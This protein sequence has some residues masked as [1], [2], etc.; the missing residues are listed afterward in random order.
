MQK[1]MKY[2]SAVALAAV[3]CLVSLGAEARSSVHMNHTTDQTVPP[4]QGAMHTQGT[5]PQASTGDVGVWG[6]TKEVSSDVWQGTK[7]VGSDV[8]QGTK[9]V[10]SDIWDG[11]K[12]VGS[13]VSDAVSGNDGA[14]TSNPPAAHPQ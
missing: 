11:A 12:K 7:E 4:A 8:W 10:S 2:I 6:K 14:P 3:F 5:M 9:D 13:D 1:K